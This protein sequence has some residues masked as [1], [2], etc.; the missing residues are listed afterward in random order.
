[1]DSRITELLNGW[2]ADVVQLEWER[3]EALRRVADLEAERAIHIHLLSEALHRLQRV[4]EIARHQKLCLTKHA[5]RRGMSYGEQVLHANRYLDA[6]VRRPIAR[7][8]PQ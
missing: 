8:R 2:A 4:T 3:D 6:R 7:E 1:M 5:R